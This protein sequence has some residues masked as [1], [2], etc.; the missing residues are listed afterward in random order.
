[1]KI[2]IC[3]HN[4]SIRQ[5]LGEIIS[6]LGHKPTFALSAEHCLEMYTQNEPDLVL[7]DI[8]LPHIDGFEAS[9]K[10]RKSSNNF[11][12]WTPIFYLAEKLDD[13]LI[14]K[15]IDAGGDD[16]LIKPVSPVLMKAKLKSLRRLVTLRENLMDYGKQL[17]DVNDKL[18]ST[19]QLL[20]ELSLKD[21]LTRLGNRRAFEENMLRSCR[22][23]IRVGKP[24]SLLMIDVD[25]FK[26]YNDTYGH[27]AGD[28]CLQ[29]VAQ[30]IERKLHRAADFGARYG[31]EEFAVVL[32]HTPK[33]GAIYVGE[34]IKQDIEELMIQNQ[35][36]KNGIVTVSVGVACFH[37]DE[38]FESEQL[39][40]AADA[41]LY[42]AKDKGRNQ[43]VVSEVINPNQLKQA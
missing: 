40:A 34:A 38:E 43:V 13:N 4:E 39:V 6:E 25:Y 33:E 41:A 8:D 15:G 23:A 19:N 31:G 28:L 32:P 9:I 10:L 3:D 18:M 26:N 35:G 29:Q 20:S 30:V 16:Y 22:T 17:Q 5:S 36:T 2:L 7:I 1:M 42:L 14:S 24:L 27:Q 12:Q 11:A 21:P 37:P